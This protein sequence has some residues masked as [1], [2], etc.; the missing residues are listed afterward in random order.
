MWLTLLMALPAQASAPTGSPLEPSPDDVCATLSAFNAKASMPIGEIDR[1]TCAELARGQT[2]TL[3]QKRPDGLFRAVGLA[4]AGQPKE[5]VWLSTQDPHFAGEEAIEANLEL[6]PDGGVWYG[7]LDIPRPFADRHWV[8]ETW[9]NKA[10]AKASG[11]AIWEHPWRLRNGETARVRPKVERG[12][13][14]GLSLE[15]FDE[16]VE[17]SVNEGALVFLDLP[18]EDSL[19]LY[20]VT[21]VIGGGIPDRLVAG[22]VRSTMSGYIDE[23]VKRARRV[24]PGH[25]RAGHSPLEGGGGQHLPYYP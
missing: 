19:F 16:A 25:Y 22:F 20:H 2:V 13:V 24:V 12:E 5:G 23:T 8:L 11:G 14:A 10:L 9:N 4:R 7:M 15:V 6:R 17:T 21:T 18:G 1:E 3:I